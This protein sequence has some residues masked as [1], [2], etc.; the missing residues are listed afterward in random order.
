MVAPANRSATPNPTS[1]PLGP[2]AV[3]PYPAATPPVGV[4]PGVAVVE[5]P[6]DGTCVLP[7]VASALECGALDAD[8]VEAGALWSPVCEGCVGGVCGATVLPVLPDRVPDG[9]FDGAV[10]GGV[11]TMK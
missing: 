5:A 3:V 9:G 4:D 2:R 8:E 10:G 1:G 11:C 6:G 7:V